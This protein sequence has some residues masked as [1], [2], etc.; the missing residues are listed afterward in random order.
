MLTVVG[1]RYRR[2]RVLTRPGKGGQACPHLSETQNCDPEPCYVWNITTGPCQLVYYS[3]SRSNCG[4]GE[5]RRII[6]CVDQ[7][8]VG[9]YSWYR[10]GQEGGG[11]RLNCFSGYRQA[12]RIIGC[13]DQGVGG[14][15]L[16]YLAF[17][18]YAFVRVLKRS[19]L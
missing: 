18:Y 2:R 15:R 1:Q 6:G 16:L 10:Q 11:G 7:R 8:G 17:I 4:I 5:A 14:G 13:V 9:C 3:R 12:R 19:K